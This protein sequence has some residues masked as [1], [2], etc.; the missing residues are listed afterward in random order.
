[1]HRQILSHLALAVTATVIA[2]C[3]FDSSA[4]DARPPCDADEDCAI[5]VCVSGSC[6]ESEPL[7][8]GNDAA[9]DAGGDATADTT[10]DADVTDGGNPDG[11]TDTNLDGGTDTDSPDTDIPDGAT[12]EPGTTICG[13]NTVLRC[14]DDGE[15]AEDEAC[16]EG[17]CQDGACTVVECV[18]GQLSCVGESLVTCTD[19]GVA[20]VD[21]LCSA[22]EAFCDPVPEPH[23]EPRVCTP[24]AL[25]CG[26]A[27]DVEVCDER[28][29]RW[30][31][32][33]SCEDDELCADGECIPLVCTPETQRCVG[34]FVYAT[35]NEDGQSSTVTPCDDGTYCQTTDGVS[36][37]LPQVCEPNSRRCT[38]DFRTA[39]ICD[40]RGTGYVVSIDCEA[41]EVCQEGICGAQVCE[42][43]TTACDGDFSYL[44][45]DATG[46]GGTRV[47]CD[48]GLYCNDAADADPDALC[49]PQL[50]APG[51]RV[52]E[53]ATLIA[54]CAQN[55][56]DY[57]DN[58]LCGEGTA[59]LDGECTS[60]VC[61]PRDF[62]CPTLGVSEVCNDSGTAWDEIPCGDATFCSVSDSACI[63][64]VCEPGVTECTDGDR[65]V[66]DDFGS[67]TEL[68]E[69][70]EFSCDEGECQPNVCGDG[71]V[72]TEDGETCDDGNDDLCDGCEACQLQTAIA[73][74]ST[75][76]TI[77]TA[78]YQPAQTD[79]TLE[80]WANVTTESGALF[81]LGERTGEDHVWVGVVGGMVMAEVSMAADAIVRVTGSTRVTGTGWH[82]IAVERFDIWGL[83]IFIDGELDGLVHTPL[84][85]S[86]I[87]VEAQIWVGSEGTTTGAN[88]TLDGLRLSDMR[89]YTTRF[90][91]ARVLTS[92]S[93]TAALYQFNGAGVSNGIDASGNGR[94][95]LFSNAA[96]L[97][98]ACYGADADA[99]DC[100]DGEQASWEECDDGNATDR[101]GCSTCT[102]DVCASDEVR[103]PDDQCYWFRGS[104]DWPDHR[105]NCDNRTNSG[106]VTINNATENDWVA[107]FLDLTEPVWIGLHD[108]YYSRDEGNYRWDRGSSS[109]RSWNTGEPNNSGA[110]AIN[111]GEDCV[112]ML[113]SSAGAGA[114]YWND[115]DCE[116]EMPAICER[117]P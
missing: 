6:F 32:Q 116:R 88:A 101:D 46:T 89:R 2:G 42:P 52:C 43:S 27:N 80:A 60:T 83:A 82:H 111:V 75:T 40:E 100:G 55:G 4:L 14:Q 66:C 35:C 23:C 34:P 33:V 26:D 51:S 7:D 15:Y 47:F 58:A 9:P 19:D 74:T 63:P 114:S 31:F 45:C 94:N 61:S 117:T 11:G 93:N 69:V 38:D 71:V 41:G 110:S 17:P 50:C 29:E 72:S 39:E 62:R 18:P 104:N 10:G 67:G 108:R 5:G 112:N 109:Y 44:E 79:L 49:V 103:G 28:G 53:A 25:Q 98:D 64:Q 81:G 24:D 102:T 97:P 30:R 77:S 68:L 78:A 76:A 106:L 1:M 85:S 65:F 113:G 36:S 96:R 8:I 13:G 59:C 3:S 20:I 91:P 107:F 95:L 87:N 115:S 54:I 48:A 21:A 84:S 57:D 22:S 37:C 86:S 16:T 73:I 90:T 92:D 105:D 70:C 12:C 56:S 99:R